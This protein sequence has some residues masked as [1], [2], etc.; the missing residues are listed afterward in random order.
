[1]CLYNTCFHSCLHGS[2]N[3]KN[4]IVHLWLVRNPVKGMSGRRPNM[5]SYFQ[6]M[7]RSCCGWCG[8]ELGWFIGRL[9]DLWNSTLCINL[10]PQLLLVMT[11]SSHGSW[12]E[13]LLSQQVRLTPKREWISTE[14]WRAREIQ[15]QRGER[16]LLSLW[17]ESGR[18]H[19]LVQQRSSA[20][21]SLATLSPLNSREKCTDARLDW[22]WLS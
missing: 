12:R 15:R 9:V 5:A 22:D 16:S 18:R 8:S 14:G 11:C 20:S 4:F 19:W 1:M 10:W 2:S 13:S 3:P 6:I 7:S 17:T 21:G